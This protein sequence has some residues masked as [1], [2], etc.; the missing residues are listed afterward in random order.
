M[1]P[2]STFASVSTRPGSKRAHRD[3]SGFGG[4]ALLA[5]A[6]N[7]K[8]TLPINKVSWLPAQVYSKYLAPLYGRRKAL[9]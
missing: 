6:G 3:T 2:Y 4:F 7:D 8:S 9:A 1:Q 5:T